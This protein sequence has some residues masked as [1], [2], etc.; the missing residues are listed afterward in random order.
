MC[1]VRGVLR[2]REKMQEKMQR[3]RQQECLAV[4]ADEMCRR[5]S[6]GVCLFARKAN[7]VLWSATTYPPYV[8]AQANRALK[9]LAQLLRD[10]G[11][12]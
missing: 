1:R 9:S 8:I 12:Y 7:C 6:G 3:Q 2:V 4:C 5:H 11:R 10:H